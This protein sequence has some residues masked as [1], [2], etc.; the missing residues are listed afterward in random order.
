MDMFVQ[1]Q[2]IQWLEHGGGGGGGKE[3][4]RGREKTRE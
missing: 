3:G 1:H 4:K 2:V